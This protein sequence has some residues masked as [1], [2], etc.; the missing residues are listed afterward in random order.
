MERHFLGVGVWSSIPSGLLFGL[1]AFDGSRK[2]RG[3]AVRSGI[4]VSAVFDLVFY[5]DMFTTLLDLSSQ[6]IAE[7]DI[8]L[9]CVEM[10]K[11]LNV[12][13]KNEQLCDMILDVG[14]GD[15]RARFEAHRIV[16]CAASPFF[17]NALN[18]DM[19]EKKEGVIR[20]VET[21]KAVMEE[22]LEYLYT[23]HVDL[24]EHNA[25]DLLETADFLD[26]QSLKELSSKF[27]SQTLSCSNCIKAYYSAETY[28]CPELQRAARDFALTNFVDVTDSPEWLNLSV[29][30][31]EEWI[32][33][34][35]LI[36]KTEEEVFQV[37][38]KWMERSESRKLPRFFELFRH[39]RLIYVSRNFLFNVIFPHPL[40]KD[41]EACRQ[42]ALD[43]MRELSFGTEECYFV[44]QPR[45]CLKKHEDA[46]VACG[47]KETLCY[48][49]SENKWYKLAGMTP[50]LLNAGHASCRM[51]TVASCHG[52]LYLSGMSTDSKGVAVRY[53]PSVNHWAPVLVF[54]CK[55][56]A[57][58]NFQGYLYLIGGVTNS[59]VT[60]TNVY[61]YNPDT[62]EWLEVAPLSIG[63]VGVCVVA[64]SNSLYA[65]GGISQTA[66]GQ[67]S[68]DVVER[69]HPDRNIWSTIASICYK[70][71]FAR[72]AIV[73][74]KVFVFGGF[75]RSTNSCITKI[76]EMYD[77]ATGTWSS[78]Q[79]LN[80]PKVIYD[81]VTFKGKVFV[82]SLSEQDGFSER[83]L[84]AYDVDKKE[85]EACSSIPYSN[86]LFMLSP[87]RIP[88]VTC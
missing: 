61:K 5:I 10:M 76:I 35:D 80:A 74:D 7:T 39:V 48:L 55:F 26:V 13:R 49:P 38:V 14:S 23:G 25:F 66:E 63:R 72:G 85:S 65:I 62:N 12:Q 28:Q 24:N 52:K 50:N 11:R 6:P 46:I 4:P 9:F 2:L 27:I 8:H 57:A 41:S 68:M 36:V 1:C 83:V 42:F 81:A 69:F 56:A 17:Y 29:T 88:K 86:N 15:D 22:V 75:D 71:A 79:W 70:R 47:C 40:V 73:R 58:V 78:I 21:S 87:L 64:D 33:S 3:L 44:Q 18:S 30:Q 32:S 84:Q 16:L 77:P 60:E 54:P 31:V 34:D 53:D 37:I 45:R 19:K 51:A 43:A 20:L 67:K 59:L 82:L